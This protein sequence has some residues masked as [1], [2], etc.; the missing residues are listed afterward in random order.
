MSVDAEDPLDFPS[1]KRQRL[2]TDILKDRSSAAPQPMRNEE[3][4]NVKNNIEPQPTRNEEH[5][6][7]ELI[8]SSNVPAQPWK[9]PEV[10]DLSDDE[11]EK[12][13]NINVESYEWYYIDPQGAIQGPFPIGLLRVW[14]E[15]GY[16]PPDFKVWRSGQNQN[17]AVLLSNL[18]SWAYQ[19]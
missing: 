3:I 2:L 1:E 14:K 15:C 6:V 4:V 13:S 19:S 16:F 11:D 7:A 10:I 5:K 12:V 18:L 17:H 9:R 8:G